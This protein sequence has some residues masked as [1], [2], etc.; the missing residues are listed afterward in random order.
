L[1]TPGRQQRNL[2][3]GSKRQFDNTTR[4]SHLCQ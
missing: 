4:P 2:S 3:E 1:E